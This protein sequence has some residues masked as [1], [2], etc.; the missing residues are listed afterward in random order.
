MTKPKD[1]ERPN[2]AAGDV[3]DISLPKNAEP[4]KAPDT[5]DPNDPNTFSRPARFGLHDTAIYVDPNNNDLWACDFGFDNGHSAHCTTEVG[6]QRWAVEASD[7]RYSTGPDARLDVG[8]V[9]V[10]LDNLEALEPTDGGGPLTRTRQE[11]SARRTNRAPHSAPK[12]TPAKAA[13]KKS[14]AAKK[15]A[16]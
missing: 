1:D 9:A 4:R 7:E 2:P 10:I 13:A 11:S 3:V 5:A 16:R 12:P 8:D 6:G 14:S 15:S